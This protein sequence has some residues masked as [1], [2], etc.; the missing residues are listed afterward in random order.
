M[1]ILLLFGYSHCS[2]YPGAFQIVKNLE[3]KFLQLHLRG[4]KCL[5]CYGVRKKYI[6]LSPRGIPSMLSHGFLSLVEL[7]PSENQFFSLFWGL[8]LVS[9][10]WCSGDSLLSFT[11][12]WPHQSLECVTKARDRQSSGGDCGKLL[13]CSKEL[14]FFTEGPVNSMS[15][16][17]IF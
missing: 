9:L 3:D 12:G 2:F 4:L 5:K 13:P 14:H 10:P 1:T 8:Y 16:L 7:L 6:W 17:H 15:T 11:D